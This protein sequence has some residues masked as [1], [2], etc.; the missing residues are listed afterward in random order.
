M[1][2]SAGHAGSTRGAGAVTNLFDIGWPVSKM[3][4]ALDA[5]ARF[6]GL[7][8]ERTGEAPPTWEAAEL[9]DASFDRWVEACA[10]WLSIDAEPVELVHH[11][12]RRVL[13]SVSPAIV[14]VPDG[15]VV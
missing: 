13:R 9:S 2:G 4:E 6:A 1:V 5:C 3:L 12:I 15:P 10:E 7:P 14:R 11:E 8:C